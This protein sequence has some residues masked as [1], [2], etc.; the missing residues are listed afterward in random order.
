MR[1]IQWPLAV[2]AVID[3]T[4]DEPRLVTGHLDQFGASQLTSV[5]ETPANP[6]P[7]PHVL[8]VSDPASTAD[9]RR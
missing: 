9:V 5:S 2:T 4:G 7:L 3:I 1:E 8:A 6:R